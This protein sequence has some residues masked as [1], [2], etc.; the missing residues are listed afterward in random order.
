MNKNTRNLFAFKTSLV[1]MS[2]RMMSTS[3]NLPHLPVP[4]FNQTLEELKSTAGSFAISQEEFSEFCQLVNEFKEKTGPKLHGLL[5]QKASQN[6]NW[7]YDWWVNKAY[8]EGRDPL[9]IWSN[10]GLICPRI[11]V[12]KGRQNAL[13]YITNLAMGVLDFREFLR[14]GENP[15]PGVSGSCMDQYTKV[16]GTTRIPGIETDEIKFGSISDSLKSISFIISRKGDFYQ[17]TVP[18]EFSKEDA[19]LFLSQCFN[20]ILFHEDA[21]HDS[22]SSL[23]SMTTLPRDEWAKYFAKLDSNSVNSIIESQFILSLDHVQNEVDFE[24]NWSECMGRQILHA[25]SDNIGNRWF[26]KTIQVIVVLNKNGEKVIGSGLCYEHTPAEG[27][28]IVRLMEH[29]MKFLAK[30]SAAG[31]ISGFDKWSPPSSDF[32]LRQL[33]F[34]SSD[35]EVRKGIEEGVAFHSK[36]IDSIDLR[37]L[38]F[39]DYGKNLI[40]SFKVSPDSYI[41]VAINW[42][43]QRLHKAVGACY[44]SASSRKFA[45]GRTECIRSVTPEFFKFTLDPNLQNL[46]AAVDSHK[47]TVKRASDGRGIDRLLLGMNAAAHEVKSNNWKWGTPP[48][49]VTDQDMAVLDKLYK[50]DLFIRSKFFKLSTSQVV[51]IF[52]DSFMI[53]GPLVT[54]GYGCCYNP[55]KDRIT[56]GISAFNEMAGEA[57]PTNADKYKECLKDT[58]LIM[59]NMFVS[60]I[61]SKL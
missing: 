15:E 54:L 1:D 14:R 19:S 27:P 17:V 53:Y 3:N 7:L 25:D 37:V 33:N 39:N 13:K 12:P 26:D 34:G 38:E 57:S 32:T 4:D 44:E 22:I 23:G 28:P 20:S 59:K 21:D 52:P 31:D 47:E 49:P 42:S 16:F 55:T 51:T 5:T 61:E 30:Q 11:D 46:K 40:K 45:F 43:F 9:I 18:S 48:T 10:P 50:N 41:Q 36:L 60:S 2:S 58:L 29:A 6:P 8:L 56:F 35:P 24:Q